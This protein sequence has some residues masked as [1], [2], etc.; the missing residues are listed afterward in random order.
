MHL[1][2]LVHPAIARIYGGGG[3]DGVPYFTMEPVDGERIDVFCDRRRLGI[4]ERLLLLPVCSALEH[5]HR[6]LVVHRDLKPSNLLVTRDGEPK[7][8]DFG[9]SRRSRVCVRRCRRVCAGVCAA[10]STPSS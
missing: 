5:A 6:N 2:R 8:V 1:A 7:L 3:V 4:A 10:T 9:I